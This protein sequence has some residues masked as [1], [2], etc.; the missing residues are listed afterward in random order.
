VQAEGFE[1][2]PYLG[3]ARGARTVFD[4]HNVEYL[5]QRSAWQTER[6]SP[7]R[8]HAA[9]YSFVQWRRL[10][11]WERRYA[12]ESDAVLAVSKQ[13][14]QALSM[15]SG[16][17]VSLVENGI[18]LA[19]RPFRA[20][21]E[22]AVPELLFDGTLSFR[23]NDD[24]ARWLCGEIVPLI[25]RTVPAVRCWV[26][27]RGPSA[28]LTSFNYGNCGVAVTGAVPSVEPYWNRASVYLLPM[29]MGGGVR[30]KALEAMARGLPIVSTRLGMQGTGAE[31]G[32]DFLPAD[33]APSFARATVR[34]LESVDLRRQLAT[35]ARR[36][37]AALD[38]A[39][40]APRLRRVY[41]RLEAGG[42]RGTDR[43]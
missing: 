43:C 6:Q 8:V 3:L 25:R 16:R 23:P 40:I 37:V 36:T 2:A 9:G 14:A 32:R 42:D 12:R 15:L 39:A 5:L 17:E 7:T 35:S 13:D 38:W 41:D 33:D 4:D 31:P 28:R 27:G 11:S 19:S 30:F 22:V 1:M 24:A 29:R 10:R 18:E 21:G 34:L 26:V 20:P